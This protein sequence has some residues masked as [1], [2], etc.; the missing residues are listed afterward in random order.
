MKFR[1]SCR[2]GQYSLMEVYFE[3]Q[4]ILDMWR[5]LAGLYSSKMSVDNEQKQKRVKSRSKR[6]KLVVVA[7]ICNLST[8]EAKVITANS[9]TGWLQN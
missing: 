6:A 5:E 9:R 1:V 2:L 8:W 7:H 3:F 4:I